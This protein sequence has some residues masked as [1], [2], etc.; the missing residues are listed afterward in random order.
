MKSKSLPCQ[1]RVRVSLTRHDSFVMLDSDP[2]M[3]SMVSMMVSMVRVWYGR[4][5]PTPSPMVRV[6][7]GR[8]TPT[9][10]PI[11]RVWFDRCR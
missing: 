6:W 1:G 9:P 3:V 5:N 4:P 11:V 2:M 7:Y 8:P 10:S